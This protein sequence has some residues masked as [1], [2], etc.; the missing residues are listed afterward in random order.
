[1]TS[2]SEAR[3]RSTQQAKRESG[4]M[5]ADEGMAT[6]MDSTRTPSRRCFCGAGEGESGRVWWVLGGGRTRGETSGALNVSERFTMAR[7]KMVVVE[8]RLLLREVVVL[9]RGDGLVSAWTRPRDVARRESFRSMCCM[10]G[11]SLSG[12]SQTQV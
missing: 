1:M 2:D 7:W 12:T 9:A 10:I 5:D 4:P 3:E 11:N 8:L 6:T